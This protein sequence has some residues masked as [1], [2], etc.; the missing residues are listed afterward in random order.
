MADFNS[1]LAYLGKETLEDIAHL[2]WL[3]SFDED[4]IDDEIKA[5]LAD[6]KNS[7]AAAGER[8]RRFLNYLINHPLAH[9]PDRSPQWKALLSYCESLTPLQT[10]AMRNLLGRE[11]N[12]G[13]LPMPDEVHLKFPRDHEVKLTAQ[14]GWHFLVGSCWDSAGVEYGVEFML[15]GD[16]LFPPKIATEF[17]LSDLENQ[18]IEMQ[19][20]ISKKSEDHLQ[21]EPI[22]SMGTSGLLSVASEPFS[23]RLGRNGFESQRPGE[24]FP[25]RVQAWGLD[26]GGDEP[27]EL[28]I[29]LML[30][31]GKEYLAQGEN[32]AMPSIDGMGTFYYSIP[33]IQIDS[34][35]SSLSM[36]GKKVQLVRGNLW[37]DHQ[38]GYL[39]TVPRSRVLKAA[40][41]S[42]AP[43]PEGWDWFMVQFIG[44]R[45]VTMFAPHS[46]EFLDF[47]FQTGDDP[48]GPMTRRV[49]GTYMDTDRST[50][51]VWG[52]MLVDNWV[53]TERSPRPDRYPPTNTW[54][55]NHYRFTF[56]DLPEEIATFTLTPIVGG[57]QSAFFASGVQI[58]EGAVVVA[59]SKGTDIGR[60]FA[61][62]V[63][64]ADGLPT[65]ARL[66]GLPD[67]EEMVEFLRARRPAFGTRARNTLYVLAHQR[68]LKEVLAQSRGMEFFIEGFEPEKSTDGK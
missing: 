5:A 38:W 11:A 55:P 28:A 2:L 24:L 17:G 35:A 25:L 56:E 52:T 31:S 26:R 37:F 15:F 23:F 49:G 16:A 48:P 62:A 3:T 53:K 61:E 50:R 22:V 29:D 9:V 64:Y 67:T 60:G 46:N 21:A 58:C 59:D 4:R 20:A 43:D 32:G 12:Q 33:N 6:Y 47:Y 39:S 18:A 1:D 40:K 45:Q 30:A 68:E 34:N 66:A 8:M 41:Y 42:S 13:Y 63:Y 54:H 27:V 57:G 14:T 51:L 44:D 19:F 65:M 36:Y 7:S 10:Y